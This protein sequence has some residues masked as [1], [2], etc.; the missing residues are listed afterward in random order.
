MHFTIKV[1]LFCLIISLM[2]SKVFDGY[3][4]LLMVNSDVIHFLF[5]Y[6]AFFLI[7]DIIFFEYSEILRCQSSSPHG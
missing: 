5:N 4:N 6:K 7:T 2:S 3:N 1:L